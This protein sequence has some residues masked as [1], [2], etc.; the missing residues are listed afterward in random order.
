MM[1]AGRPHAGQKPESVWTTPCA[2]SSFELLPAGGLL[3]AHPGHAQGPGRLLQLLLL[4][5]HPL[6]PGPGALAAPGSMPWPR[7]KA[8]AQEGYREIVHHRHRDRLLGP[9]NGTTAAPWATCSQA[10]LAAVPETRVRLGS[11]EPRIIDEALLP[12]TASG[13]SESLP[14]VPPLPA[15]PGATPCSSG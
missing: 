12:Q 13:F 1:D 14:P 7:R 4:L 9:R 6:R 15:E 5:H 3:G 10:I 2:A 8:L 11:L